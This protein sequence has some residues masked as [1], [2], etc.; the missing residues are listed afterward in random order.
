M[1]NIGRLIAIGTILALLILSGVAIAR[2][3]TFSTVPQSTA[4][5]DDTS[6]VLY[7]NVTT[8]I[9]YINQVT[10]HYKVVASMSLQQSAGTPDQWSSDPSGVYSVS[11][12]SSAMTTEAGVSPQSTTVTVS[13]QLY[14]N[15]QLQTYSDPISTFGVSVYAYYTPSIGNDAFKIPYNGGNGQTTYSTSVTDV[16]SMTTPGWF[17]DQNATNS[18]NS[19]SGIVM[20]EVNIAFKNSGNGITYSMPSMVAEQYVVPGTGTFNLPSLTAQVGQP[21]TISGTINY[22]N[23]NLVI[24]APNGQVTTDNIGP[25]ANLNTPF[26]YKFTPTQTGIYTVVLSNTMVGLTQTQVISVKQLLTQAP[27]IIVKTTTSTGYYLNGQTI[28]F[29]ITE[30]QNG[31]NFANPEFNLLIYNGNQEPVSGS[32]NFYINGNVKATLSNGYYTYSG[33]FV[34]NPNGQALGTI[35]IVASFITGNYSAGS[36]ATHIT[37]RVGYQS[38]TIPTYLAYEIGI[39][40]LV[41]A[42]LVA[43]FDKTDLILRYAVF[44]MGVATFIVFFM[45]GAGIFV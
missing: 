13:V 11:V 8:G 26:N 7:F 40:A 42:G 1:K 44:G 17:F 33:S 3:Q 9:P 28:K 23:F 12:P 2:P 19:M 27:T 35:S 29:E 37:I 41:A 20:F 43:A 18:Y 15:G 10:T 34:V 21:T 22:G 16:T 6:S 4:L 14:V 25:N 31:T 24:T 5:Y 45:V 36:Q 38:V 32:G 30:P 39:I